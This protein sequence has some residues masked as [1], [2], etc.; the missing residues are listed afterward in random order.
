MAA[1]PVIPTGKRPSSRASETGVAPRF[2]MPA[3]RT[4]SA[5]A[6]DPDLGHWEAWWFFN[7]HDYLALKAHLYRADP[8]TGM[9]AFFLGHGKRGQ[10]GAL[11]PSA[12]QVQGEVVPALLKAIF[13]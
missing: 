1:V 9:D 12:G 8:E 4:T 5:G 11:A 10:D 13:L 7:K 3:N 6:M 2:N